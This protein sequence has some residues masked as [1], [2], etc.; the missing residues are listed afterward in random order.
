MSVS[1]EVNGIHRPFPAAR[2]YG[3]IANH[4]GRYH[5]DAQPFD[6]PSPQRRSEPKL[7]IL[8]LLDRQANPA[9]FRGH[10]SC[11]QLPV[12]HGPLALTHA[13]RQPGEANLETLVRRVGGR[14]AAR[15]EIRNHFGFLLAEGGEQRCPPQVLGALVLPPGEQSNHDQCAAQ[16]RGEHRPFPPLQEFLREIPKLGRPGLDGGVFEMPANVGRQVFGGVVAP[17][18]VFFQR[19][20]DDPVEISP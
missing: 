4:D 18:S 15:D 12:H 5:H 14:R 7:G 10:D 9:D 1:V 8:D 20:Q 6:V 17:R 19:L 16:A 13:I 2:P 3:G 11:E